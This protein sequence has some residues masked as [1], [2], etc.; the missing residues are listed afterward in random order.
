MRYLGRIGTALA[1]IAALVALAASTSLAGAGTALAGNFGEVTFIHGADGPPTAGEEREIRFSLLQH[2]VA[3]IEDGR[4]DVTLT[5]AG[6]GQELTVQATHL[7]DGIWAAAVT[8]PVDGD[9]RIA[10]GHEWFETSEPTTMAVAPVE[11]ISWLPA[12][13]AVAALAGA[14]SGVVAGMRLL[15]RQPAAAGRAVRAEG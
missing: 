8:F 5:H 9:W 10:I 3:P 6:T 13:I 2:G 1:G 12:T 15:G 11:G 7:G 14:A 4:V